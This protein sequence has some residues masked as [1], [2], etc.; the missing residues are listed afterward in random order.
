MERINRLNQTLLGAGLA[1]SL[2]LALAHGSQALAQGSWE[3]SAFGDVAAMP[4][5]IGDLA[6]ATTGGKLY[7]VGSVGT[8]A[9]TPN[10][11]FI[12]D[13]VLDTW[14]TGLEMPD[15]EG[16]AKRQGGMRGAAIAGKVYVVGGARDVDSNSPTGASLVYDPGSGP[17]TDSWTQIAS[18]PTPRLPPAVAAIDGKLYAVGGWSHCGLTCSTYANL[19]VYDPG[20]DAWTIKTPM[21][22]SR[23]GPGAGAIGGKLY[24]VGGLFRNPANRPWDAHVIGTLE[25]YDP[26]TD[27]WD[28]SKAP[29]PTP[30]KHAA[31][32]VIGGRL[33]VVGGHRFEVV[34]SGSTGTVITS[35]IVATHEV[36]D[37]AT[38]TWQ[39]LPPMPTARQAAGAGVID[40]RLYVAGGTGSGGAV[41]ILEVFTPGP[42]ILVEP[43]VA[44]FG[45]IDAFT[46]QD[47]IV[48]ISNVGGG[49]L[50]VTGVAVTAGTSDFMVSDIELSGL[51]VF[52]PFTLAAGEDAFVTVSF[53]PT[54]V[55]GHAGTLTVDSA[56]ADEPS[57]AVS[58]IGNGLIGAVEDQATVLEAAVE[59]AIA[60]G[61][62]VG[63]GSGNSSNGRL[64]AFANMID[65]A[66]DLIEAGL[67]EDACGQLR[68][69]LRRVDGDP[70]PPDFATGDDAAL[71][72]EQ[73]EF[74]R[75]SLGCG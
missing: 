36:Y 53:F 47:T 23:E 57:V 60:V 13:P 2:G 16:S 26:A 49:D 33:H 30:R 32:A 28:T 22:T 21:P 44:D 56:D 71:I 73:I 31:V 51:P 62:L 66:G 24:V 12:Y 18:M 65:A 27:T 74:L 15:V 46:S 68:S 41:D 4:D 61:G 50:D 7:F 35:E 14:S 40:S 3:S 72:A 20:T 6:G 11:P 37:P 54:A 70:R 59:E 55:G 10:F 34:P 5:P 17:G 52:P 64:N 67:I 29:M 8:T 69:A 38:D 58:L 42:D 25:I 19:E 63:S 75:T 43:L 45:Q 1:I 39:S 9:F 48:T